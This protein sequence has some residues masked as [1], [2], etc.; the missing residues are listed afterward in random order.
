MKLYVNERLFSLPHCFSIL[1]SKN[2]LVYD[3]IYKFFSIG[4]KITINDSDGNKVSYI[5][6]E[7]ITLT[8]TYNVYINDELEFTITKKIQLFYNDY[9][10][11]NNYRVEGS[12]A[13]FE[14]VIYDDKDNQIASINRKFVSIGDKYEITIEDKSKINIILSIIMVI[15]SDVNRRQNSD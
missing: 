10:L 15:A 6:Q 4:Y 5:E 8:P 2:N 9:K 1:D 7:L 12:F 3:V 11:S 14:F 13:M